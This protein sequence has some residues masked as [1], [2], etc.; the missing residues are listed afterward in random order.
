MTS[1]SFWITFGLIGQLLFTG[2]FIVQWLSS[3]RE[4][5]SIIP[6]AFW[7]LSISGGIVL[8]IYALH[9][10]DPVFVLGQSTG[11]FIYLRNIHLLARARQQEAEQKAVALSAQTATLTLPVTAE[12]SPATSQPTRRA[13]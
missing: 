1:E 8:L 11:L 10:A 13:A 3:E 2:R 4:G 6:N 5:R 7:Y 9:R 12:N